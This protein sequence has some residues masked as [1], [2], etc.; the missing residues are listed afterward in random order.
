VLSSVSEPPLKM[1]IHHTLILIAVSVLVAASPSPMVSTQHLMP[2]FF[3]THQE[4]RMARKLGWLVA[5]TMHVKLS[6][7]VVFLSFVHVRSLTWI[8]I[9]LWRGRLRLHH[10]A[11][12]EKLRRCQP[13]RAGRGRLHRSQPHPAGRE[14]LHRSQPHLAGGGREVQHQHRAGRKFEIDRGLVFWH[15]L[16]HLGM[17][18]L[19][20]NLKLFSFRVF[21]TWLVVVLTLIWGFLL[22]TARCGYIM[23]LQT[24]SWTRTATEVARW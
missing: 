8:I 2:I 23:S 14:K 20:M 24:W 18:Y 10:L 11:G 22:P 15:E 4:V 16:A 21:I 13:L 6:P 9:P 7:C 17:F 3:M 1:L 19:G 12:R 5:W